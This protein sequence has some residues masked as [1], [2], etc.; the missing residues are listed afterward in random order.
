M[1]VL[2]GFFLSASALSAADYDLIRDSYGRPVL[3]AGL[4][5]LEDTN[6][7][8]SAME[9]TNALAA[10]LSNTHITMADAQ[11]NLYLADKESHSIL[12]ITPDGTIHTV[13]GTHVAGNG[14]DAPQLGTQVALA[15]PN[16]LY[17]LPEGTV[18]ILDLD[19]DKIRRLDTN[20][21]VRTVIADTGP[22]GTGRG[23]WVSPD[24]S[25]IFYT[26]SSEVRKWT[27][28]SGMST[29]PAS[30]TN[31]SRGAGVP[32][33]FRVTK[34]ASREVSAWRRGET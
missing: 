30:H 31:S 27:A 1:Q 17:V 24:G 34:S 13:V 32:R 19:N 15:K 21:A 18:Y 20:G 3:V 33:R 29:R 26:A 7:W 11:R 25:N 10:E 14:G 23:L 16:G 4:G 5:Q 2:C 6:G 9:G 12:K 28:T 22:L 8:G